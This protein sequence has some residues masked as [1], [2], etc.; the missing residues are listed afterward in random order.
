MLND[1]EIAKLV[2]AYFPGGTVAHILQ[3]PVPL[4]AQV[5][6]VDQAGERRTM[7]IVQGRVL[8][9]DGKEPRKRTRKKKG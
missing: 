6:L 3:P 4:A 2:A 9:H 1:A 7:T 5:V 8:S